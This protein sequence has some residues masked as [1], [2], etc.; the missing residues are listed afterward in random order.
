MACQ[1]KN[2]AVYVELQLES[3]DPPSPIHNV[4]FIAHILE[5]HILHKKVV[6]SLDLTK[7]LQISEREAIR[8]L[9]KHINVSQGDGLGRV[10]VSITGMHQELGH[11]ILNELLAQCFADDLITPQHEA[12]SYVIIQRGI[13]VR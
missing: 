11:R 5:S 7:E 1:N 10:F 12:I 2:S 13:Q 3:G 9:D 6:S 4:G 8:L